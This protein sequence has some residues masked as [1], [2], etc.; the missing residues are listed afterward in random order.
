[1][2]EP[3]KIEPLHS[4]S[5][6]P[7]QGHGCLLGICRNVRSHHRLGRINHGKILARSLHSSTALGKAKAQN[8]WLKNT[9]ADG[10]GIARLDAKTSAASLREALRIHLEDLI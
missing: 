6:L 9:F 8:F 2:P 3:P 4:L 5:V 10:D 7:G 1:M